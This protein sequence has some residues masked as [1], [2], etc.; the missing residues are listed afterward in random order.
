[1]S[2]GGPTAA[3]PPPTGAAVGAPPVDPRRAP[4]ERGALVPA[5]LLSLG[6]VVL[7]LLVA[8][9]W[10]RRGPAPLRP[11]ALPGRA[12]APLPAG[13]WTRAEPLEALIVELTVDRRALVVGGPPVAGPWTHGAALHLPA[14]VPLMDVVEALVALDAGGPP[15]PVLLIGPVLRLEGPMSPQEVARALPGRAIVPVSAA[16]APAGGGLGRP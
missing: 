6:L 14:P 11:R 13:L 5:L 8:R 7:V 16:G 3:G 12:P 15:C 4:A 1:M 9:L 10:S 2:G